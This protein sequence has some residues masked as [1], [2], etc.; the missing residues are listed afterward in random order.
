MTGLQWAVL[1]AYARTLPLGIERFRLRSLTYAQRPA[2]MGVA[3]VQAAALGYLKNGHLT[4]SGMRAAWVYLDVM[5]RDM[6]R[7]A[8]ERSRTGQRE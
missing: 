7:A 8:R 3:L 5:A 2:R 6:E 4:L 1:Q